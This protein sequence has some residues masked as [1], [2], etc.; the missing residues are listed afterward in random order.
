MELFH[1]A[2]PSCFLFLDKDFYLWPFPPY[3]FVEEAIPQLPCA[4]S[5]IGRSPRFCLDGNLFCPTP[6]A[7]KNIF[8]DGNPGGD[9]DA[10]KCSLQ[11]NVQNRHQHA[12]VPTKAGDSVNEH[13]LDL[14]SEN[15]NNDSPASEHTIPT[16][17]VTAH[18]VVIS[19]G[20]S[21]VH[22]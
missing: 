9:R 14:P 2:L 16:V 18:F 15:R 5:A 4:F 11:A 10:G 13:I 3:F 1:S 8:K 12:F 22:S 17:C 7:E 19:T 20:I 21:I 6:P